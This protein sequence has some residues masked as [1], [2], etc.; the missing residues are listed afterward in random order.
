MTE[1]LAVEIP[2]I[3]EEDIQDEEKRFNLKAR[4]ATAAAI[5]GVGVSAFFAQKYGWIHGDWPPPMRSFKHPWIG[6]YSAWIGDRVFKKGKAAAGT[7]LGQ[8]ANAGAKTA[9]GA[10]NHPHGG[11]FYWLHS[12]RGHEANLDNVMDFVLCLGG[13]ALYFAQT[14]DISGRLRGGAARLFGRTPVSSD[15]EV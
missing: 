7:L 13:T 9:Q 5:G 14:R 10:V 6:Y 12:Q 4:I 3:P 11:D 8:A 15:A 1:V 2:D